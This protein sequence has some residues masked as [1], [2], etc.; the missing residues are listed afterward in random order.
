M[1]LLL[2]IYYFL[3]I[4][5]LNIELWEYSPKSILTIKEAIF[6][7]ATYLKKDETFIV[8]YNIS[9]SSYFKI[10]KA[11]K[12]IE[13]N[14]IISPLSYYINYKDIILLTEN[15]I[16]YTYINSK[17]KKLKIDDSNIK[18]LKV[19]FVNNYNDLLISL[20]GTNTMIYVKIEDGEIKNSILTFDDIEI[21]N[22]CHF[23]SNSTD[24]YHVLYKENNNYIIGFY[25]YYNKELNTLSNF[26]LNI[27]LYNITEMYYS[28]ENI[29]QT[30]LLI[31]FSYNKNEKYFNFYVFE[32][33]ND[34]Y[35][36]NN[37]GNKY[38][39][40]PFRNAQIIKAFFLPFS[41]YLYYLIKIENEKYAGVLDIINNIIIYNFKIT[42]EFISFRNYFLV[43]SE[44]NILYQVC[45]FNTKEKDNCI[46]NSKKLIKKAKNINSLVDKCSS[47]DLYNL[48]GIY[49][50]DNCPSGYNISG[51][52][53]LKC[54]YDI[55][56]QK[57]VDS[58]K[59][60][61]IYDELNGICYSC[62]PFKQYKNSVL[63]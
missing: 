42:T 25:S 6:T 33:N 58:C 3:K 29:Y 4:I 45:P 14:D 15:N 37:F 61:Q 10:V 35:I 47:D 9:K 49:C 27:E 12:K 56:N 62:K 31:L 51:K 34:K 11:K 26:N 22:I 19:S 17:I 41:E 18:S 1:K 55:D 54:L 48:R 28:I 46:L 13:I 5:C 8:S 50:Y 43:Y 53:C 59:D 36:L 16:I 23:A 63:N 7:G 52:N 38:N 24:Y 40:L 32:F 20:I 60:Q 30:N 57:C 21:I 39:F 44:K 2:I